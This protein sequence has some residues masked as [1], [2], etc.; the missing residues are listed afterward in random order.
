M[1]IYTHVRVYTTAMASCIMKFMGGK[2]MMVNFWMG[3]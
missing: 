3:K 1:A 2:I